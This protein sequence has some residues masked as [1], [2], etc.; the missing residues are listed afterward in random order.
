MLDMFQNHMDFILIILSLIRFIT[1]IYKY[2]QYLYLLIFLYYLI[3][4]LRISV[5]MFTHSILFI[6]ET[7]PP[8]C[9]STFYRN[10]KDVIKKF[11]NYSLFPL[12]SYL[13]QSLN[14]IVLW[15]K[16]LSNVAYPQIIYFFILSQ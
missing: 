7:F 4:I 11:D 8:N 15:N 5:Y 10:N 3:L 13:T 1:F 2:F 14:K 6:L 12:H 16:V 9:L